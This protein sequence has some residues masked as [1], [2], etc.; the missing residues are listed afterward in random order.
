MG[1]KHFLFTEYE[2]KGQRGHIG[3]QE[4]LWVWTEA[5]KGGNEDVPRK[6][7]GEPQFCL[8]PHSL[9][10]FLAFPLLFVKVS[11]I[12]ALALIV[13]LNFE[14]EQALVIAFDKAYIW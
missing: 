7:R 12:M 8:A 11:F 6:N 5:K 14:R 1:K 13:G 10:L 9:F 3:S 4:H 2:N